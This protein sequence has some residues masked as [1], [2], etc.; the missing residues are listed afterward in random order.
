MSLRYNYLRG[1]KV[2]LISRLYTISCVD[3]FSFGNT[4]CC[5]T[6]FLYLDI[7]TWFETLSTVATDN[8][9]NISTF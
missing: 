4:I 6:F 8:H 3:W 1:C 7:L 9:S 5:P 2:P